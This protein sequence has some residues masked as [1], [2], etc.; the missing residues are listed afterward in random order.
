LGWPRIRET[1]DGKIR[2]QACYRDIKGKIRSAGT[3]TTEKQAEKAWQCAEA[4]IA[5]GRIGDPKRG[6]QKF[7]RYV[8]EEWFPNHVIEA[9]TRQNYHYLIHAYLLP[10]FGKMRMIDILPSHVREWV[11]KLQEKEVGAPTIKQCKVILN[12]IFTTALNDQITVLHAGKGASTPAVAKKQKVIVTVTQFDAIYAELDEA[13]YQILVE[14]DIETGL[15]WGELVELR[16]KDLDQ[17]SGD[18]T[19]KRVAVE[20][21]GKFHPSGERFLI[22]D[23][24]KDG[25]WRTLRLPHHLVEKL[26][27]WIELKGLGTD[28][29]LFPFEQPAEPRRMIRPDELPDPETLGYT[30]PNEKG[31]TYL[32]GTKT[33]YTAAK[34]RCQHCRNAMSAYRAERRAGGKDAPRP[35]RLVKTDGHIPRDYFRRNI[36]NPA[37]KR[38]GIDMHVTPHGL[39][40]AH[41]SWLLAGGADIQVVKDRLGHGSIVTTQN[42]L[43]TLPGADESALKA[44]D[45]IRGARTSAPAAAPTALSAE[46]LAEYEALKKAKEASDAGRAVLEVGGGQ[47]IVSAEEYAEFEQLRK[48]ME[49]MKAALAS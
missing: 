48:K 44:M 26:I 41:A 17:K 22:K 31:R 32:H 24:P 3:Y 21:N 11:T 39:R 27:A 19:V 18:L 15:R 42:Y 2:Y 43:H 49:A 1:E 46:Q 33:A 34:C 5:L 10:E 4:K 40:H 20:L 37:I 45:A 9:S 38:S 6:R 14:T 35:L 12:A 7:R 13:L 25:E 29:L 23:Y 8:I 30:E 16:V 36:W 28:D 47:M